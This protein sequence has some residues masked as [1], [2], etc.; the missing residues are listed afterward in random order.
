MPCPEAPAL[1]EAI[2]A[3]GGRF[4]ARLVAWEPHL[5]GFRIEGGQL[6]QVRALV[7]A[8]RLVSDA[9]V[10]LGGPTATSHPQEV[11]TDCDAD[12][13]F[14]GEA[15]ETLSLFLQ[16]ARRH[17]SK[18]L[19]PEIPGL[20]FR[21]GGRT[22]MNTLPRDGYGQTAADGD[23]A[24]CGPLPGCLR[25]LVRPVASQQVIAASRLDWS[26][27][28]NFATPF[29]SLFFTG[30]RGCPGACT[31]CAKLHGQEVRTKT[32]GQMLDEITAADARLAEGAIRLR[33]W[34]LF[35]FVDD[36]GL[37]DRE[38]GWAAIFDE[39]FFCTASERW[40]FSASGRRAP[41]RLATA[42]VSR[43]IPAPC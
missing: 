23:R 16:L 28:E 35:R 30:G 12:Y 43:P 10:I 31:F 4:L 2:R 11:L 5:V 8:V 22:W 14:A 25:N 1:D 40:S 42:S 39:D 41:C 24:R 19:Q 34:R 13:V 33:R 6:E 20:S 26:L 18:D 36:P 27:L 29:D 9:E 3:A 37:R 21:Y 38:V 32:A 15:E 17:N 7:R